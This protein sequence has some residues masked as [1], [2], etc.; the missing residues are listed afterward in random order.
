MLNKKISSHVLESVKTLKSNIM[1]SSV[2]R[3]IQ[4]LI[5]T[6]TN[7]GEGKSTLTALLGMSMAEA[8][9]KTLI[10]DTDLRRPTLG[11][12]IG[13]RTKKGLCNILMGEV[14]L[15]DT[16]IKTEVKDL[17]FLDAGPVPP[18][19]VEMIGSHRF[20]EFMQ[21]AKEQ[22]DM[23]IYDMAPVGLFIEP[24]LVAAK[25]DGVVMVVAQ[26]ETDKKEAM[27]ARVQLERAHAKILGVVFNKARV[28]ASGGYYDKDRYY[29]DYYDARTGV[30]KET[31]KKKRFKL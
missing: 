23:I 9:K 17:Y 6:S 7:A 20:D 15:Q 11:N 28:T 29:Y 30:K 10:V 5:L 14:K 16:V 21:T 19:P 24:A 8:G 27:E 18:N 13:H 25:T 4:S 26:G 22:F 12:T 3:P 2:D 31:G 1:F